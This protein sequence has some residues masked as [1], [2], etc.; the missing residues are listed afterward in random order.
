MTLATL[1]LV[2]NCLLA[3]ISKKRSLERSEYSVTGDFNTVEECLCATKKFPTDVILLDTDL[4]TTD[5]LHAIAHLKKISP[6]TKIIVIS[7]FLG[8][9]SALNTLSNGISAYI[10][11]EKREVNFLNIL[12]TVVKG[13]FHIDIEMA[14]QIF[15][16]VTQ[17]EKEEL[18]ML[19]DKSLFEDNLTQREMEVLKLMIDGKTNSQIAR[20]I[21]ISTNTA[22]AHVGNILS[23][24]SVT[25]RVQA[26]VKA[27][28]AN[29]F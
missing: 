21:I 12:D 1:Y 6:K 28:R 24:L 15:D 23:K 17:N 22:K 14:N 3:R 25:D 8:D 7:S 29:I 16:D 20:E 4:I 13:E 11:K 27:V 18:C 10:S 19:T 26:A 9:K 2:D 5:I